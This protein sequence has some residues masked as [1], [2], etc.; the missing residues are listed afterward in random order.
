MGEDFVPRV[1]GVGSQVR[2]VCG[3]ALRKVR[4]GR[5]TPVL[6]VAGKSKAWGRSSW[7]ADTVV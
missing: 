5:G 4:E 3:P 6:V 2:G 7:R 1:G